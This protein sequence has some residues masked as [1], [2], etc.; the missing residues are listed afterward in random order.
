MQIENQRA[1][2]LRPAQTISMN[3]EQKLYVIANDHGYSCFGFE[4]AREHANQIA[5]I[6][7]RADLAFTPSDFASLAGYKKYEAA[8]SAWSQS[9]LTQHTYFEPGTA[10][11]A[12]HVLETNRRTGAKVRLVLGNTE[13]GEPWLNDYD[14]IGTIG[15]SNGALKVPLLVENGQSGGGA[16]LTANLLHIVEWKSGRTL[17]RHRAYR[18]P[19]LSLQRSKTSK[20]PWAVLH[21]GAVLARFEDMGKACAYIAFMCGVTVEPRVFQ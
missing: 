20:H 10:E 21:K 3:V 17:Y 1:G 9:S 16:I 19:V 5:Q 8:I 14:V 4:N 15:R 7:H 13:N 6:L 11:E 18:E 2:L 12:A